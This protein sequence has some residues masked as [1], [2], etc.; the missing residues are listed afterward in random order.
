[1]ADRSP[2]VLLLFLGGTVTLG[3]VLYAAS[4]RQE[5]SLLPSAVSRGALAEAI[6]HLREYER[7]MTAA[8]NNEECGMCRDLEAKV[9]SAN[10]SPEER[11]R[12]HEELLRLKDAMERGLEGAAMRAEFRSMPILRKFIEEVH[13]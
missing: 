11:V 4:R 3:I 7:S 1:M 12:A 13:H 2:G 8:Q 6:G 9:A 10:L 5:T